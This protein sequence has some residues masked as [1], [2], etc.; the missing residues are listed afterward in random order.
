MSAGRIAQS[1]KRRN[2]SPTISYSITGTVAHVSHPVTHTNRL[3][4][5][6]QTFAQNEI[7]SFTDIKKTTRTSL[8]EPKAQQKVIN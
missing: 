5:I 4:F 7:K 8:P 6:M 3:K 2:G 1:E